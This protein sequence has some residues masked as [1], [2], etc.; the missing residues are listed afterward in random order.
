M[1]VVSYSRV[2]TPAVIDPFKNPHN[3]ACCFSFG[4][5]TQPYG[6]IHAKRVSSERK[7]EV[8]RSSAAAADYLEDRQFGVDGIYM[9]SEGSDDNV[10]FPV[11]QGAPRPQPWAIA[12]SQ[13]PAPSAPRALRA[14]GTLQPR[15]SRN[16]LPCSEEVL[17]WRDYDAA[18][19]A[20]RPQGIHCMLPEFFVEEQCNKCGKKRDDDP[21]QH[22]RRAELQIIRGE[23]IIYVCTWVRLDGQLVEFD[24]S[25]DALYAATPRVVYSRVFLFA[26]LELCV[27]GKYIMSAWCE[28]LTSLLRN[29][30]AYADREV[31]RARQLL[32]NAVGDSPDTLMI[33]A[34]AFECPRY[35]ED[36][37]VVVAP[38]E[39]GGGPRSLSRPERLARSR[40]TGRCCPL[41]K[42][43]LRP[44]YGRPYLLPPPTF[45]LHL[46]A[47]W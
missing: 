29:T 45:P 13:G 23:V 28:F 10:P 7:I 42:S 38:E 22:L 26:T 30:G 47:P 37:T 25:H 4:F 46:L 11:V 16:M 40:R 35:G 15:R 12:A 3:L 24:G 14:P 18:V 31:G 5:L 36:K 32:S 21:V 43:T 27:I 17:L 6:C 33:P 9:V 2:W 41:P 44:C 8:A 34:C 1:Y 20:A 39:D 19:D